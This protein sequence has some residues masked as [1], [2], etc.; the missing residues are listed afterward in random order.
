MSN[1]PNI[2]ATDKDGNELSDRQIEV[3]GI[4]PGEGDGGESYFV[5][6]DG[7][8]TP[9]S[10]AD[11]IDA[12]SVAFHVATPEADTHAA[13][14]Q[15]VDAVAND[16]SDLTASDIDAIPTDEKGAANGVATLDSNGVL[17]GSE[18]PSI[19][20]T[21]VYVI[22]SE[23]DL[24]TLSEA[25]QGDVGIATEEEG[26]WILSDDPYD[27]ESNWKELKTE[28]PPVQEVFGRTG[29]ITAQDG[30]YA[31]GQL[32]NVDV[33]AL[34][35][36]PIGDRPSSGD[37][38]EGARYHA[39]DQ[40]LIYR[41]ASNGWRV[42]HGRGSEDNPL[43]EQHVESLSTDSLTNNGHPSQNPKELIKYT[44]S[45]S[46]LEISEIDDSTDVI[47]E[48]ELLDYR[49][50]DGDN[51]PI[52]MTFSGAST[53]DYLLVDETG[54]YTHVTGDDKIDLIRPTASSDSDTHTGKWYLTFDDLRYGIWGN[55]AHGFLSEG[56]SL[57]KT[58]ARGNPDSQPD[59]TI[60][61]QSPDVPEFEVAIWKTQNRGEI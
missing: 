53:Y 41:N 35:E 52:E 46:S 21:D 56:K 18:L 42:T 27:D 5:L 16:L 12:S 8:L 51:N 26:S 13:Q 3:N 19:V 15:D 9:V 50:D 44:D 47:Y 20:I 48:I 17:D 45:G 7:T 33:S 14:K 59:I 10:S 40:D 2:I 22:D 57:V 29:S 30:D 24:T 25:E 1:N 37:V 39:T 55:G 4:V 54:S 61:T 32:E 38:P 60:E 31:L 36:G 58:M 6:D 43:P 11:A 34:L 28:E 49:D 23:A